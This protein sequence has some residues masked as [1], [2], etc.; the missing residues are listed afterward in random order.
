VYRSRRVYEF[1]LLHVW[2]LVSWNMV[3]GEPL[4]LE[5]VQGVVRAG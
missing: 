1:A 4:K 3:K 5:E 2:L